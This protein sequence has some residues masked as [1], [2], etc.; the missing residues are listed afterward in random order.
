DRGAGAPT[1][2]ARGVVARRADFVY[3]RG[4]RALWLPLGACLAVACFNPTL[5]YAANTLQC[6]P[7]GEC[8][9][10]YEC[11]GG[12]CAKIGAPDAPVLPI[13]APSID[14]NSA[15]ALV[16]VASTVTFPSVAVNTTSA[17]QSL[18]VKNGGG[19]PSGPVTFSL[20]P[21]GMS[22]F[23]VDG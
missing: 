8:P 15:A 4:V 9:P 14:P 17:P 18:T 11:T 3:A 19:Q 20:T 10:N 1:F 23:S 22:A 12:F 21:I 2:R 16:F 6:G 7:S 5:E 13:D